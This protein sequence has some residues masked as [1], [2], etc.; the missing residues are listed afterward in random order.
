MFAE[1]KQLADSFITEWLGTSSLRKGS[2]PESRMTEFSTQRCQ[3]PRG[4]RTVQMED[5]WIEDTLRLGQKMNL[6]VHLVQIG[7]SRVI[8]QSRLMSDYRR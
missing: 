5:A 2:K 6:D 4:R 7:V 1:K 8:S 3:R